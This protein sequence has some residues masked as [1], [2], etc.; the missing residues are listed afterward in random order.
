MH[1][2]LRALTL[3]KNLRLHWFA[4]L[5]SNYG[6]TWITTDGSN[7]GNPDQIGRYCVTMKFLVGVFTTVGKIW[8][9][10][11]RHIFVYGASAPRCPI[12]VMMSEGNLRN[13]CKYLNMNTPLDPDVQK[14]VDNLNIVE[15]ILW[16][17]PYSTQ[18]FMINYCQLRKN[19]MKSSNEVKMGS[20]TTKW[21]KNLIKRNWIDSRLLTPPTHSTLSIIFWFNYKTTFQAEMFLLENWTISF[22]LPKL[23]TKDTSLS[24]TYP[25]Q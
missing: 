15:E 8:F 24:D 17:S 5:S 14:R 23:T 20:T 9:W 10:R 18:N 13:I 7:S 12:L 3:W 4:L 2:C 16:R 6:A 25:G 21:R 22:W 11:V 19:T 1:R